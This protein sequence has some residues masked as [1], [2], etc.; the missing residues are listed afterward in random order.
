MATINPD[1][2]LLEPVA[3]INPVADYP[4]FGII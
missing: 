3:W 2:S 4:V 1:P